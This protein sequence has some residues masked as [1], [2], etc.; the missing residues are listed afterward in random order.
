MVKT[1]LINGKNFVYDP[2]RH[3][4]VS[5]TPE[6]QVRQNLIENL[7]TENNYPLTMFSVEKQLLV[8]EKKI[9]Y[10]IVIYKKTKPWM[11]VECKSP[12]IKINQAVI[13]QSI[14]YQYILQ[15]PYIV[16][17]NGLTLYCLAFK[18]HEQPQILNKLPLYKE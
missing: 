7:A 4:W 17:T 15:A 10:D 12:Q 5:L 14:A 9:R 18:P 13:N 2:C 16:L 6:E 11:L 3:K 1:K 8:G